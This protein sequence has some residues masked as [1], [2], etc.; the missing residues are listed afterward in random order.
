MAMDKSKMQ[1]LD[2]DQLDQVSGGVATTPENIE[3]II[4]LGSTQETNQ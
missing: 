1:S 3:K 2:L 4:N